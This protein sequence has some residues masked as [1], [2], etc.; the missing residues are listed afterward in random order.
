MAAIGPEEAMT[1]DDADLNYFWHLQ[2]E[3]NQELKENFIGHGP[4]HCELPSLDIRLRE[5]L[6]RQYREAGW[7]VEYESSVDGSWL[8][9]SLPAKQS[10]AN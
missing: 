7:E 1:P 9:F 4:V 3:I 5:E 6:I 2:D 8:K 10:R